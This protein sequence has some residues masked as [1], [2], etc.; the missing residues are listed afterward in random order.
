MELSLAAVVSAIVPAI[1]KELKLTKPD[2]FGN[3]LVYLLR[4]PSGG[5]VLPYDWSLKASGVDSGA[6]L[7]LD[8]YT[9]E[10]SVATLMQDRQA[11]T[12]PSFYSA[13][14]IADSMS[15]PASGKDT[16]GSF[17]AVGQRRKR[18]RWTRRA[19]LMLGGA[20]LGAG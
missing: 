14:T 6:R 17:P 2:L 18:S 11:H 7:A 10:G 15:L 20:V 3:K 13:Q 1:V 19:L 12:Q 9:M 16:S 4:Y 5:H 8:S